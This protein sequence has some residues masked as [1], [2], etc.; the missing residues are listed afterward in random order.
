MLYTSR[1]AGHCGDGITCVLQ[2][3]FAVQL[4]EHIVEKDV[5]PPNTKRT[6]PPA[7]RVEQ[8]VDEGAP[9]LDIAPSEEEPRPADRVDGW[10]F[11]TPLRGEVGAQYTM[12]GR[13]VLQEVPCLGVRLAPLQSPKG[14]QP[15]GL[16]LPRNAFFD[17]LVDKLRDVDG[18]SAL[19]DRQDS[20]PPICSLRLDKHNV[21]VRVDDRDE[22]FELTHVVDGEPAEPRYRDGADVWCW[23]ARV[24]HAQCEQFRV[25]AYRRFPATRR[26]K[27]TLPRNVTSDC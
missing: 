6:R 24:G 7:E 27:R 22:D 20:V 19:F 16:P 17:T 23:R 11:G 13:N 3:K 12:E 5:P 2:N 14:L 8:A 21:V 1:S 26:R 18:V 25:A 4:R 15:H 9:S 10:V